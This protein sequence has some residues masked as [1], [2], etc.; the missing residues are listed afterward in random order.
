MRAGCLLAVG[1]RTAR[2]SNKFSSVQFSRC[3]SPREPHRMSCT[4]PVI[5]PAYTALCKHYDALK[6]RAAG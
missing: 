5:A 3:R 4:P 1:A 6:A 2:G